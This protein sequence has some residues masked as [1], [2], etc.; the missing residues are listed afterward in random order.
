MT[1]RSIKIYTLLF[2]CL[3][4]IPFSTYAVK[5]T[6]PKSEQL[7]ELNKETIIQELENAKGGKLNFLEKIFVKSAIKKAR[8]KSKKEKI[9]GG[10]KKGMATAAMLLGIA[11]FLG[12]FGVALIVIGILSAILAIIFGSIASKRAKNDPTTYGGRIMAIM[13]LVFGIIYLG[14]IVGFALLLILVFLGV[15][16]IW[17]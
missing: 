1:K 12:F 6:P 3:F 8:K 16:S 11:S 2:V 15:T 4:A 9:E 7:I 17:G 14:I 10:E 5:P 13:G